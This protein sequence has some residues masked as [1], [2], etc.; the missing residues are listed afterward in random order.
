MAFQ[1]PDLP[2]DYN[3]LEP[4]IDEKT[5]RIHHDKHHNAYTNGLNSALEKHPDLQSKPIEELL[6]NIETVPAD[7][8]GAV[9]FHGGGFFNHSV[10]WQNMS[11]N[12]G[13]QPSGDVADAINSAF[14]SFEKFQEQFK[15]AATSIQGSGW[16]WLAYNPDT[17]EV[18]IRQMP[19]QTSILTE[20]L[21]PLLGLDM[22]EHAF[23]L[24]YQ[25]DKGAYVDAWWNVVNWDD[26]AKRLKDAR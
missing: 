14:G 13:G 1:L 5:M 22:W 11:P 25:N 2:Y 16:A 6:S 10:F 8:R 9:N 18:E 23:Y 12:G 21:K 17:G 7:I 26:V 24:K 19:N 3:A 4:H 15:A 20:G